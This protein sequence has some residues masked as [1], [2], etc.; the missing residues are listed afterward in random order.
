MYQLATDRFRNR[1]AYTTDQNIVLPP[2]TNYNLN[3]TYIPNHKVQT[4][5]WA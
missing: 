5:K 1:P 3:L 2:S 4:I